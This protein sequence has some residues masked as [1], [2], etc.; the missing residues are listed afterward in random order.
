MAG[1]KRWIEMG[2]APSP[3]KSHGPKRRRKPLL[4]FLLVF[5]RFLHFF[6][7]ELA[8]AEQDDSLTE[9]RKTRGPPALRCGSALR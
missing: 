9:G 8:Q 3:G 6:R 5:S 1:F 2:T 7:T 4:S